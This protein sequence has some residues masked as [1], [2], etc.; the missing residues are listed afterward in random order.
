MPITVHNNETL[1]NV[2]FRLEEHVFNNCKLT[3]CHLF[4]DGGPFQWINCSFENCQWSFRERAR[5]TIQ[6]LNT[7]GLMKAG[8]VPPQNLQGTAGPVN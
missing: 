2:A 7:L 8:Q 1:K 6:L 5:D 4:Y 3:N